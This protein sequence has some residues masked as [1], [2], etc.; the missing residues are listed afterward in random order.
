MD[1]KEQI[2][3]ALGLNK[4][5][6][7]KLEFQAKTEDGTIVV[8]T[9]DELASGV[10]ISVLTEDGTT[11]P[12]PPGTYKLDTGVSFIVEEEGKVSEVME[13]E[14]EE[15]E[16]EEEEEKEE[17]AKE[18]EED[19][20]EHKDKE[21]ADYDFEEV[22][23]RLAKL[24]EEIEELKKKDYDEHEEKEEELSEELPEP[25][26]KPRTKTT[27]TTETI[28]FSLEELKAENDK[29]RAELDKS[30]ADAPITTKKT[31]SARVSLSKRDYNRLNKNEKFLYNL[32][33]L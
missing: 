13:A 17:M 4:A 33:K 30:P 14:A 9:A 15:T 6:E 31:G 5:E 21:M 26:D 23:K 10:D 2:L 18:D 7:I 28:E 25:S 19:Y 27:K 16:A 29:L 1:I 3:V 12:L 11:I 8:S 24:E 32:N 20:D 22:E